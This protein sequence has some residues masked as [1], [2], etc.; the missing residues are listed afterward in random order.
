MMIGEVRGKKRETVYIGKIVSYIIYP[1]SLKLQRKGKDRISD[2]MGMSELD[3]QMSYK[4]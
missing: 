3:T 2:L 1:S 4:D